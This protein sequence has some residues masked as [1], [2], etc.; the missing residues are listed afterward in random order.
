MMSMKLSDAAILNIKM[1]D[2][3]GI[4]NGFIIDE[5]ITLMQNVDLTKKAEHYK[6]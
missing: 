2:Y 1:S 5:A 3:C 6:I 4:I